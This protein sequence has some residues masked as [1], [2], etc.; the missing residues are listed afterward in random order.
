MKSDLDQASEL[1]AKLQ[2]LAK[3]IALPRPNIPRSGDEVAIDQ[4][5]VFGNLL[6]VLARYMDGAQT[7][8]KR[9]TVVLTVLTA[10]L[11]VDAFARYFVH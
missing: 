8:I 3:Q 2:E 4:L 6:L 11:V 7:T 10:L 9:L 5:A 1:V